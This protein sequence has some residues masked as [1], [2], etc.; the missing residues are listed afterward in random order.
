MTAKATA[1]QERFSL[2]FTNPALLL[3]ALRASGVTDSEGNK[4][5][6]L[7]GDTG[8]QFALQV[9]GRER[10]ASRER[11]NQVISETAGNANLA[12]RGFALGLE[13]YIRNNPSQGTYFSD[14]LMASTMEAIVGAYFEDQARDFVALQ[15]VVATLGLSWPE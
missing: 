4:G 7:I 6:A 8:L 1:F 11:V 5:L 9:E 14:R 3:E 12:R 15:R 13:Q 2:H 10:H